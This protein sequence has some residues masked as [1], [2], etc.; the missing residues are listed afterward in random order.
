MVGR[1]TD[2]V[3]T[4]ALQGA[5]EITARH[6]WTAGGV[7]AL[8]ALLTAIGVVGRRTVTA[9]A[10]FPL[11]SRTR[12]G[13]IHSYVHFPASCDRRHPPRQPLSSASAYVKTASHSFS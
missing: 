2:E 6:G 7:L 10:V 9:T 12:P 8:I 5:A 11:Q 1:L 13:N 3:A 4:P